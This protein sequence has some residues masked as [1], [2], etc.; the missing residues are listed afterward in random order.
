MPNPFSKGPTIPYPDLEGSENLKL[1]QLNE[2]LIAIDNHLYALRKELSYWN[3]YQISYSVDNTD[4]FSI[5]LSSLAPGEALIINFEGILSYEGVEY[6]R[7]DVIVRLT[8]GE[9]VTI[10]GSSAGFYYPCQIVAEPGTKL[11]T[12]KYRY[13]QGAKANSGEQSIPSSGILSKPYEFETYQVQGGEVSDSFIYGI[14]E[15]IA[16]GTNAYSYSFDVAKKDNNLIPPIIKFFN[17]NGE[18][19]WMDFSCT[20]NGAGSAATQYT[21]SLN[22]RPKTALKMYIK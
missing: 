21:V 16:A 2:N 6:K 22:S 15:E 7:G 8:N 4:D 12:L 10:E 20:A 9:Y 1:A 18:E 13:Y 14:K 19:L 11:Y 3:L 17:S 5:I